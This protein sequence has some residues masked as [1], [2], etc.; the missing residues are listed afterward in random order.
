M[1]VGVLQTVASLS[2][3][4]WNH[5]SCTYGEYIGSQSSQHFHQYATLMSPNKG[6]T[7]VCGSTSLVWDDWG[8][9]HCFPS[10]GRSHCPPAC[11]TLLQ[12]SKLV[13][14]LI[15]PVISH[16]MSLVSTY[17]IE[18]CVLAWSH[19]NSFLDQLFKL[20]SMRRLDIIAIVSLSLSY[21]L[22]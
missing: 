16:S 13:G 21:N 18:N 10:I 17:A 8:G 12:W 14:V 7:A 15:L 2:A 4:V 20:L 6:K 19:S 5:K 22:P 3:F 11:L 1:L 9:D